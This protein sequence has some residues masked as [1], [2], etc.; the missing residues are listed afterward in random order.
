MI[1]FLSPK[2]WLCFEAIFDS[3]SSLQSNP[4]SANI[5]SEANSSLE[6]I[7]DLVLGSNLDH[8]NI[9]SNV[10]SGIVDGQ[11]DSNLQRNGHK[12]LTAVSGDS[13]D[14]INRNSLQTQDSFGRW[15]TYVITDSPDSV[16]TGDQNLESSLSNGHETSR[17]GDQQQSSFS[18]QIFS[19]T[20]VSPASA[21]TTEETKVLLF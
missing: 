3:R 7:S 10:Y 15:M 16:L 1:V 17:L 4:L 6:K 13:L 5:Y 20:D 21:F 12:P 14:T 2:C 9:S 11:I 18:E 19:I 8:S